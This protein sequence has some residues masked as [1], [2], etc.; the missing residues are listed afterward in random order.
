MQ[1]SLISALSHIQETSVV[2]N[3]KMSFSLLH[4]VVAIS[5]LTN[6]FAGHP[7]GSWPGNNIPSDVDTMGDYTENLSGLKYVANAGQPDVMYGVMNGPANLF[8]LIK[9][10]VGMWIQDPTWTKSG[11]HET[12]II[13][14]RTILYI[15]IYVY[16]YMYIIRQRASSPWEIW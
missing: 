16:M 8:R 9:N 7:K 1:L 10:N 4:A 11:I 12:K 2:K 5:L 3:S 14:I 6:V 13:L 15:S